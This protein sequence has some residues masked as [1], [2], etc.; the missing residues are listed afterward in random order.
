ML[1]NHPQQLVTL[2]Q[3]NMCCSA[4]VFVQIPKSKLIN[5]V[6][7]SQNSHLIYAQLHT[8]HSEI[9]CLP[10]GYGSA[11]SYVSCSTLSSLFLHFGKAHSCPANY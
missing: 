9:Y 8:S 2:Y 10:F 5:T 6:H 11:L 1:G 3:L 4:Y 7:R